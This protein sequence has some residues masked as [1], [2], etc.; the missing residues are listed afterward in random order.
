MDCIKVGKFIRNLRKEKRMTQKQLADIMNISDKTISKW[1]CGNGC[2]D[3]SLL[4]ELADILNVNIEKILI[5][6]IKEKKEI[7]G[8]MNKIKFYVCPICDN[9]ITSIKKTEISCCGRKLK[10]LIPQ[11]KDEKHFLNIDIIGDELYIKFNHQMNKEHYLSFI[12]NVDFNKILVT[13]L[14]PE[15]GNEVILPQISRGKIYFYCNKHGL[16]EN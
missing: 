9:V 14:Y 5:G 12:A 6:D 4:N 8:N 13:K 11:K 3:I 10:E 7:G 2:P 1:E 16:F 15:Q